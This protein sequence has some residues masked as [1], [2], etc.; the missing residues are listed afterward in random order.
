M[1]D[2]QMRSII[3]QLVRI[4]AEYNFALDALELLSLIKEYPLVLY[5]VIASTSTHSAKWL[6]Y[7]TPVP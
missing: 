3:G 6:Q 4:S 7:A 1:R 5:V 2:R